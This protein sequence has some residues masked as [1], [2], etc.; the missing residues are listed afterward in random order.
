MPMEWLFDR[1]RILII[2]ICMF[3]AARDL[4]TVI[5]AKVWRGLGD[6]PKTNVYWNSLSVTALKGHFIL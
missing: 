1:N 6:V 3:E 4:G 5:T 2:K